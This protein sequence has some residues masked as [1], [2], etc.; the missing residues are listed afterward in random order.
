MLKEEKGRFCT[1]YSDEEKRDAV[2]ERIESAPEDV[3]KALECILKGDSKL[4]DFLIRLD[5]ETPPVDVRTF[6]S[7]DYFLGMVGRNLWP[8]WLD[9]VEEAVEGGYEEV[10][11][12]GAIGTGKSFAAACLMS[13]LIY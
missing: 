13:Y 1:F 2:T 7:E 4:V 6:F 11:F 3:L 8:R 10:V 12:T 5:Y 9:D